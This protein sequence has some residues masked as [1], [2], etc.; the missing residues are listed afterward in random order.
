VADV[1]VM[2]LANSGV[3]A[4]TGTAA[5]DAWRR[6]AAIMLDAFLTDTRAPLPDPPDEQQLRRSVALLTGSS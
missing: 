5:P 3:L 6:F 2:L 1:V 4:A